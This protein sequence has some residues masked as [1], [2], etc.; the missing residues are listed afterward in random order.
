MPQTTSIFTILIA[1]ALIVFDFVV[2]RHRRASS[3][4]AHERLVHGLFIIA[5]ALLAFSGILPLAFRHPMHGW[6]LMLHMSVAPLFAICVAALAILWA[7][8]SRWTIE[9][10]L[11]M[12]GS[13]ITIAAAMLAMMTWFGSDGQRWLLSVH[14][15]SGMI[16]VIAAAGQAGRVFMTEQGGQRAGQHAASAGH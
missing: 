16:V 3:T 11:A 8:A 2:L 4:H 10:W 14:R 13:F 9:T 6:M 1:I 5:T 7:N 12:L 15:L